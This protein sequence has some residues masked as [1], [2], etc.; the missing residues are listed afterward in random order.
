MTES[1]QVVAADKLP[2]LSSWC[3][4]ARWLVVAAAAAWVVWV[5]GEASRAVPDWLTMSLANFLGAMLGFI[6][7]ICTAASP[8]VFRSWRRIAAWTAVPLVFLVAFLAI[9]SNWPLAIRVW[10]SETELRDYVACGGTE[11]GTRWEHVGLFVAKSCVVEPQCVLITT[12]YG[13]LEYGGVA[14][15]PGGRPDSQP[16]TTFWHLYGPWYKWRFSD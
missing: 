13:F 11:P 8:D 7:L 15:A 14:Y 16:F 2:A 12:D 6:W 1:S 10:L 5:I 3:A 9:R 4:R